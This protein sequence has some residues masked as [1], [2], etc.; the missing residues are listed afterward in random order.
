M[1]AAEIKAGLAQIWECLDI[2]PEDPDDDKW[3]ELYSEIDLGLDKLNRDLEYY[4]E[5]ASRYSDFEH[6]SDQQLET[7]A[8]FQRGHEQAP[9]GRKSTVKRAKWNL[10]SALK[11]FFVKPALY[12]YQ[13]REIEQK[14]PKSVVYKAMKAL[15]CF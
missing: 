12:N 1:N 13:I 2:D 5:K 9:V 10:E 8:K 3:F 11:D 4:K 14:Y 15:F 6:L 7:L